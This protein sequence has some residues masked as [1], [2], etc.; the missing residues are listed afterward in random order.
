[1]KTIKEL[2]KLGI[3]N[4]YK[5]HPLCIQRSTMNKQYKTKTNKNEL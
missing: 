3:V 2:E 1:M 5:H 4:N